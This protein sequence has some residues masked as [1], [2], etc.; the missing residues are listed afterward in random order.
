MPR[1]KRYNYNNL[2]L[3]A[4]ALLIGV[5]ILLLLQWVNS[6]KVKFVHYDAFGID[7][8]IAYSIH[9]IDVSRYQKRLPG[10]ELKK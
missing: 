8:P 7:M 10:K 4:S 2:K 6:R 9:G 3:I 1:K 5:L